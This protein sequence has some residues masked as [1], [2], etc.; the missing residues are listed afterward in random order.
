M[1]C[2]GLSANPSLF[3]FHF[4]R[5]LDWDLDSRDEGGS[6]IDSILLC[7]RGFPVIETMSFLS[8]LPVNCT[9]GYLASTSHFSLTCTTYVFHTNNSLALVLNPKF[10]SLKMGYR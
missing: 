6:S 10:C 4:A 7:L 2:R 5:K 9:I 8:N 3:S 1:F